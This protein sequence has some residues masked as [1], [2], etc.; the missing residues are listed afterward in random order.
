[1]ARS[2]VSRVTELLRAF[3][4][5]AASRAFKS[6][7][8]PPNF[9]ATMIS[10]TNLTTIWPRFCAFAS[11]P[12]CFHCAPMLTI[13]ETPS[14]AATYLR[15]GAPDQ[16]FLHFGH[17]QESSLA[18]EIGVEQTPLDGMTIDQGEAILLEVGIR[19]GQMMRRQARG[20]SE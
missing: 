6:G 15:G 20:H 3:S 11:R 7:S 17:R 1:M 10:R 2:M 14:P 4:T 9:A 8:A 12:A 16:P 18:P 13:W 19:M 5:A